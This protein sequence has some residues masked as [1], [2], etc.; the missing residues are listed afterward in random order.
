MSIAEALALIASFVSGLIFMVLAALPISRL[1]ARAPLDNSLEPEIYWPLLAGAS[2][3]NPAPDQ[4]LAIAQE[5]TRC[6]DDRSLAILRCAQGQETDP[7]MLEVIG[8]AL[9]RITKPVLGPPPGWHR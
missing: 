1:A 3:Q 9:E 7:R 4:R 2:E 6:G 5:L 8:R